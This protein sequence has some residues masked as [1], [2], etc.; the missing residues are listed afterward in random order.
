[1]G[2]AAP[3]NDHPRGEALIAQ[4]GQDEFLVAAYTAR[5]AFEPAEMDKG[6]HR[7][8]IA[9]EEGRNTKGR[10]ARTRILNGD[11][12]DYG[13]NFA[14]DPRWLRVRLAMY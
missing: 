8:F 4:L 12:T 5:V 6:R 1:M 3:G 14:T 9:V 7:Q 2:K 10:W 11:E 13:L